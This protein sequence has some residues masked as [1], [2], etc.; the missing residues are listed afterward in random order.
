MSASPELISVDALLAERDR[1]HAW[2]ARLAERAAAAPE[3]VVARV[4][5]DYR[6]RLDAVMAQLGEHR[7]T[8]TDRLAADRAELGQLQAGAIAAREGLAEAELRHLVGEYDDA[9]FTAE[10][11]RHA[12]ALAALEADLTTVAGRITQLEDVLSV[13]D[14]APTAPAPIADE[15]PI[16][17]E[18][19]APA[20]PESELAPEPELAIEPPTARPPMF[21][22][23]LLAM[24]EDGPFVEPPAPPMT[25]PADEVGPL[26]FRPSGAGPARPAVPPTTPPLGMP[27]AEEIPR[28]ARPSAPPEPPRAPEPPPV[29]E[30]E[31]LVIQHDPEPVMPSPSAGQGA[32]ETAARTLRCG[33][34]GAM[35]RP[36]EWYCEKCGAEL[37]AM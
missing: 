31:P 24:F 25:P 8:I 6:Q 7:R 2:L 22:E 12:A 35:N 19:L 27:A 33:E 18:A 13:V 10:R 9:R 23:D 28:F 17:I 20:E 16:A 11:D 37:T 32:A 3:P 34:C 14:A 5:D 1:V 4:Q 15:E 36:L 30:P 21:E 29:A 26:S